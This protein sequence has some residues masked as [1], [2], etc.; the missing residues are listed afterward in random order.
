MTAQR[1]QAEPDE[2]TSCSRCGAELQPGA[3]YCDSC[4]QRTLRARRL[5]RRVVRIE[6]IVLALI[7]VFI[8]AFSIVFFKQ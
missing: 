5:V 1:V 7:V 8:F 4:G 6:L 2:E 3:A